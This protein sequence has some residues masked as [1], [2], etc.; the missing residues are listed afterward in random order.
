MSP[1]ERA[2]SA[3][4]EPVCLHAWCHGTWLRPSGDIA[5]FPR[6]SPGDAAAPTG[7]SRPGPPSVSAGPLP[8]KRLREEGQAPL[9][10]TGSTVGPTGPR[11][12]SGPCPQGPRP[13]REAHRPGIPRGRHEALP[14]LLRQRQPLSTGRGRQGNR[15]RGGNPLGPCRAQ[16][17]EAELGAPS[18][19]PPACWGRWAGGRGG[20]KTPPG[21]ELRSCSAGPGDVRCSSDRGPRSSLSGAGGRLPLGPHPPLTPGKREADGGLGREPKFPRANPERC[22]REAPVCARPR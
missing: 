18:A 12:L 2:F 3:T 19:P 1:W 7:P 5:R 21:T 6:A 11:R 16:C 17:R 13:H 4:F 10:V 9:G 14:Q 22:P 20:I 15:R 8:R